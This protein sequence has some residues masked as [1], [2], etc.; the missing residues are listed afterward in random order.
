MDRAWL[1]KQIEKL[2]ALHKNERLDE[3]EYEARVEQWIDDIRRALHNDKLFKRIFK[4]TV[5]K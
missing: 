4:D 1:D 2:I 5:E 3:L